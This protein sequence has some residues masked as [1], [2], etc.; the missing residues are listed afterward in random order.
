ME[1]ERDAGYEADFG[2]GGFDQGVSQAAVEGGVDLGAAA[3]DAAAEVNEG[4]DAAAAGPG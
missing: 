4:V 1:S 2:V 3:A